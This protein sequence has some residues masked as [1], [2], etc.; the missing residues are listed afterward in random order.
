MDTACTAG[1]PEPGEENPRSG[2]AG[3]RIQVIPEMRERQLRDH[4]GT[5]ANAFERSDRPVDVALLAEVDALHGTLSAFL[6]SSLITGFYAPFTPFTLHCSSRFS[7]AHALQQRRKGLRAVVPTDL[8]WSQQG[9]HGLI[10]FD[11]II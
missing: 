11:E 3:T 8:W 6:C 5:P 2:Y 9:V 7:S 1:Y 4:R 10:Q